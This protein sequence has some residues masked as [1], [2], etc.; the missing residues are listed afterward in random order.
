MILVGAS[1]FG[2]EES[3]VSECFLDGHKC[4]EG[5]VVPLHSLHAVLGWNKKVMERMQCVSTTWDKVMMKVNQL[6]EFLN[7][8]LCGEL[9]ELMNNLHFLLKGSDS[10]AVDMMA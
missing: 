2:C 6:Q 1:G 7:L 10:L 4:S 9:W 5:I 3:S 8:V